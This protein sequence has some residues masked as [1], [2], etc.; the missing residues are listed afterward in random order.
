MA[1][2][3]GMRFLLDKMELWSALS[4]SNEVSC[5]VL[6]LILPLK[7]YKVEL[8]CCLI[9]PLGVMLFDEDLPDPAST[10]GNGRAEDAI[11]GEAALKRRR[12]EG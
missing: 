11:L 10:I 3:H 12:T 9:S 2:E 8:K 7:M 6:P 5:R 1:S 4:Y